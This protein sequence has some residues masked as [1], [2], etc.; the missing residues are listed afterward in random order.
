MMP[1][2]ASVVV[3]FA[4]AQTGI[5]LPQ[6]VRNRL[7]TN[8]HAR[9]AWKGLTISAFYLASVGVLFI[10][11]AKV[12][13]NWLALLCTVGS[14]VACGVLFVVGHDACH[15]ALFDQPW[16]NRSM[17]TV[18]F[19]PSFH[20]YSTWMLGHNRLHHGWTMLRGMDYVYPPLT[21]AEYRQLSAAKRWVW[22]FYHTLPGIGFYYLIEVWWKHLILRRDVSD[23]EMSKVEYR[24][25]LVLVVG[26]A[27]SVMVAGTYLAHHAG[28]PIAFAMTRAF[29]VVV[30]AFLV[31]NWIMAFVTIQHHRH[32]RAHWYASREK[33]DF[34]KGQVCGT[35][36]MKMPRVVEF[37]FG[38]ILE[39]TAH[40]V[41]KKIPMYRLRESQAA[42]EAV[43]GSDVIVEKFTPMYLI[44][45]LRACQLYDYEAHSWSRF[46][47]AA[48]KIQGGRS[49]KHSR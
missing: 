39:H 31:F 6:W 14:G 24:I 28:Q 3:D 5:P 40:H 8:R 9:S 18:C 30:G 19:L 1:N 49:E 42:L 13:S 35:V 47:A 12:E 15:E 23:T 48:E 46:D 11:A 43:F 33:W 22:R 29:C 21:V 4:P 38:N 44:R 26:F 25:D 7:P 34:Y 17:G 45:L 20:L 10:I 36:H 2:P 32:P 27:M 41:D 37:F 16:L